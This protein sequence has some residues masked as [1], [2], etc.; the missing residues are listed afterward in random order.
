MSLT[1]K[2]VQVEV[3]QTFP[4]KGFEVLE[5]Q[6]SKNP[7]VIECPEH[8][9]QRL[10]S[11][12]NFIRSK[13]GCPVCALN[14][15]SEKLKGKSG[16]ISAAVSLLKAIKSLPESL[17]NADYRSQ[18]KF[19]LQDFSEVSDESLEPVKDLK[20]REHPEGFKVVPYYTDYSVSSEGEVYSLKTDALVKG[21]WNDSAQSVMVVLRSG[22][23]TK[24]FPLARLVFSTFHPEDD[25][26]GFY[27]KHKDGDARNNR[28]ENLYLE[29]RGISKSRGILVR[30]VLNEQILEFPSIRK[31]AEAINASSVAAVSDRL[32]GRTPKSNLLNGRYEILGYKGDYQRP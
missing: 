12:S 7:I 6:G 1:L 20:R 25:L 26:D 18:V 2:D 17:S 19:L 5:Y 24:P 16:G 21:A 27:V 22:V 8:G 30:D 31:A 28:L 10:S 3:S 9:R 14:A 13:H 11:Y 15:R 32:K 23:K 29:P 4:N